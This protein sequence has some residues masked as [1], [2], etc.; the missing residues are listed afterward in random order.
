[1]K[2]QPR[3]QPVSKSLREFH[4]SRQIILIYA[5]R[6]GFTRTELVVIVAAISIL[7]SLFVSAILASRESARVSQCKHN[8]AQVCLGSRAYHET[9]RSLPCAAVWKPGPLNSWALHATNRIDIITYE[10]WVLQLLPFLKQESLAKEWKT[11][12]PIAADENTPVRTASLPQFS[13]PSDTYNRS[14]NPYLLSFESSSAP[15]IEFARGNYGLN[16]GTHYANLGSSTL[17]P[18]GDLSTMIM[19][20]ERGEFRWLGNGISGINW[21]LSF[22]DFKNGESTLIAFDELRAGI[23]SLDP[24]GVWAF[25]QPG[26]SITWSHGVNGDAYGPNNQ[27]PRSDDIQGCR[28]IHEAIGTQALLDA[29]MPCVDYVDQNQQATAR[30]QHKGGV[31]VAFVD[32][33]VRF[34]SDSINPG[35]WHVLHSRVTPADVLRSESEDDLLTRTNDLKEAWEHGPP[36]NSGDLPKE[37]I[38]S[39]GMA[40]VNIPASEFVMGEPDDGFGK[41]PPE[42]PPHR[43]KITK[44]FLLGIHE[45]TQKQFFD[46]QEQN[47]SVHTAEFAKADSVDSFPVDSVTWQEAQEFCQRL[48]ERPEEKAAGREYRLPTE[49]EWEYA[50]RSGQSGRRK[51]PDPKTATATGEAAGVTPLPVGP[52]GRF[53]PNPFGLHD[54]RGNVWEWCSDWFDRDYYSRSR[55]SDPSGP[56]TGFLKVVRGGDWKFTGERCLIDYPIMPAW[57]RNPFVGFRVVCNQV[58][59][60]K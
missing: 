46:I 23:H 42:C 2:N 34:I 25:G 60:S 9:F 21:S 24:R 44:P 51:L 26:G 57:T 17:A 40:F 1:M 16:G 54:M 12:L 3:S 31:H 20:D 35:L 53:P 52:V 36:K 56:R 37:L 55:E 49:A 41:A 5:D 14:D 18:H 28:A 39:I 47:P 19:D 48:S 29:R 27:W 30:S 45:V 10:N 15:P 43:V 4:L 38:N 22:S 11:D 33:H 6:D 8:L 58:K 50:C 13:C 32:G 7:A 59:N